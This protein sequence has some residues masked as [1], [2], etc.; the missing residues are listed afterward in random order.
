[1]ES[2]LIIAIVII[3]FLVIYLVLRYYQNI[4]ILESFASQSVPIT[5]GSL[6]TYFQQTVDSDDFMTYQNTFNDMYKPSMNSNVVK[7]PGWNG[8]WSNQS[9]NIW[10]QFIEQN[11]KLVIVLSNYSFNN[12]YSTVYNSSTISQGTYEEEGGLF[13]GI[14][15]LNSNRTIFNLQNVIENAYVNTTLGLGASSNTSTISFSGTIIGNAITLYSSNNVPIQLNLISS[16]TDSNTPSSYPYLNPYIEMITPFVSSYSSVANTEYTIA[17]SSICPTGTV[18]Y[19]DNN[20][21]VSVTS[22]GGV[23]FNSCA[24]TDSCTYTGNNINSCNTI[25]CYINPPKDS[26][27]TSCPQQTFPQINKYI[28]YGGSNSMQAM[29]GNDLSICGILNN[30]GSGKNM[31][32]YNA[33][34]LCYVSNIGNVQTLNYQFFGSLPEESTLTVQY[35]IMNSILNGT[36]TSGSSGLTEEYNNAILPYY[37][38]VIQNYSASSANANMN[39]IQNGLSLTNCMENNESAGSPNTL[40]ANCISMCQSYVQNYVQSSGNNLLLPTIWQ[41]NTNNPN[42]LTSDCPFTLSTSDEYNTPKKYIEC[43]NN[44]TI[45]LSLYPDGTKQNLIMENANVINQNSSIV[46]ISTNIRANNGLYLLPSSSYGGFSLNSNI[47]TLTSEPNPNGK[48]LV[49]GFPFN[50]MNNFIDTVKTNINI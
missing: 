43:N 18:P 9:E 37:R 23:T 25:N 49:I 48:W 11:D 33:V 2:L 8:T 29:S 40:I 22:Y 34:I 1:M 39:D 32:N 28:N 41:I 42:N 6:S 47:V 31:Y 50:N 44:G 46:I 17:T 10:A 45:N 26:I 30:F 24:N 14:G 27:L 5:Q 21:G 13:I 15:I 38:N 7:N 35:D 36:N 4:K 12:L 20:S 3:I 19:L 16:F